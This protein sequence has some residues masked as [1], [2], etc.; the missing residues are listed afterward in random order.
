M[1]SCRSA[2]PSPRD[3][4][5]CRMLF[6]QS[7]RVTCG[8]AVVHDLIVNP[9]SKRAGNAAQ[10]LFFETDT[11][12]DHLAGA[13]E[14]MDHQILAHDPAITGQ[15]D[16]LSLVVVVEVV[17]DLVYEVV[18]PVAD[19]FFADFEKG[20]EVFAAVGDLHHA[21]RGQLEETIAA[22]RVVAAVVD[23][24]SDLR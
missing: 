23:V 6:T 13:A 8:V 19:D 12:F 20:V 9:C 18:A 22:D 10:P 7:T 2:P 17:A 16:P 3:G 5:Q 1:A 14:A 4:M 24:E 15:G 11:V 21:V